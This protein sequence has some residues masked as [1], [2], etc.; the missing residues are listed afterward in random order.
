MWSSLAAYAQVGVLELNGLLV[1][2]IEHQDLTNSKIYNFLLE[3]F[4]VE[5]ETEVMDLI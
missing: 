5:R 3:P 1:I 2:I 4:I